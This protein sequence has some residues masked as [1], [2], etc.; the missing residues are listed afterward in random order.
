MSTSSVG[1]GSSNSLVQ[2]SGQTSRGTKIVTS[3]NNGMDKNTFLKILT[4]E[5]S[6]QDPDNAKDSTQYVSQM[7]QFTSL[8]QMNNLNSTMSLNSANSLMGANVTVKDLD[9]NGN[10]YSGVV[11]SVSRENGDVKLELEVDSSGTTKTFSY[12]NVTAVKYDSSTATTNQNMSLLEAAALIGKKAE[13]NEAN[14]SGDNYTGVIKAAYKSGNSI[15]F[16]VLLDGA[17]SVKDF[18]IDKLSSVFTV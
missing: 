5:L 9:S 16:S 12:N 17:S 1:S 7:A 8:E 11:K 3:A 6:N 18:S 10:A 13:F 15:N 2:N 4:T 14:S